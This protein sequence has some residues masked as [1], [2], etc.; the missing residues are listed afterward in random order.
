MSTTGTPSLVD[1]AFLKAKFEAGLDYDAYM[2]SGKPAQKESWEKIYHQIS[3]NDDQKALLAGFKREMN[4]LAISG[5]W[6]GDC[7]Q[8]MPLIQQ[9]ADAS[10]VVNIKW[11]DRDE[12]EDLSSLITINAGK[13]VPIVIFAAEDFEFVS[14][15]GD[16]TLC[17]YRSMAEAQLG[18]ACPLPGAPVP[19]DQ[20]ESTQQ[21]WLDE[22]ERVQLLLRL[23]GRLRQKHND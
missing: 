6:C 13:R 1:A 8:Q 14:W 22:F 7:V 18:N 17:R 9:F 5:I 3:L 23:S 20:L 15:Y 10:D 21:C 11:L 2:N 16:R 4:I 19:Q 12:H